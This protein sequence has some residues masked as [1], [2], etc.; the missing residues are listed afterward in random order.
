MVTKEKTLE[1]VLQESRELHTWICV[2]LVPVRPSRLG[3]LRLAIP[4]F[5][6]VLDYFTGITATVEKRAY[7]SAFSLVRSIFET[8]VR[9]VW[10]KDCAT[11]EDLAAFERDERGRNLDLIL[12]KIEE[13]EAFKSGTLSD[14]K[15]QAWSAMN[16]Y[17]HGGIHQV[18]RRVKGNAIDPNYLDGEIIEVLRM[19]QMFALLAFIQIV[20]VAGRKD[21]EQVGIQKLYELELFK[22]KSQYDQ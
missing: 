4:A 20:L 5:D 7:G 2:A 16:S 1:Q 19:G 10:L 6:V 17:T 18:A 12:A 22:K 3:N 9:A 21:L 13:L 15:K 11:K 14:L 8:F